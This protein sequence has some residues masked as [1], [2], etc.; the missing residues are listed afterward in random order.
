MPPKVSM[1]FQEDRLCE[2]ETAVVNVMLA[3]G[4]ER[5]AVE[6]LEKL[7]EKEALQK[8][9]SRLSGGQRRRVCIARA[10]AADSDILLLDEPFTGLMK[11]TKEGRLRLSLQIR[12]GG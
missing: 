9:V 11:K 7:L 1:V 2:E 12:R 4:D 5:K 3:C 8:P 6:C 10:L